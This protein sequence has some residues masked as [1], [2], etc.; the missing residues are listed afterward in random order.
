M[1]AWDPSPT[2]GV[3]GYVM[4]WGVRSG[5]YTSTLDVG[6]TLSAQVP[7]LADGTTYFF[8]VQAYNATTALS[9]YSNEV[10]G[11]TSAAAAPL[12]VTCNAPTASS[13]NGGP[14]GAQVVTT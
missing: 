14:V 2:S 8:A 3:P 13:P 7:G 9:T 11:Q 10:T 5:V 1:L 12:A 6:N 4:S